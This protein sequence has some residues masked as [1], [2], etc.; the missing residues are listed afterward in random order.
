[1]VT[2]AD[3]V[4][5]TL[6]W[7]RP[8]V[9][10]AAVDGL[11]TLGGYVGTLVALL[12]YPRTAAR[13]GE[14]A[15]LAIDTM[16]SV[17]G[18][19]LL[20]WVLVTQATASLVAEPGTVWWVRVFGLSQLALIAGLNVVI[21]RG[22]AVPSTRAFWWFISGQAL[23]VPVVLLSQLFEARL[24]AAW[25]IDLVYY[26]GV[27]PTFV[28]AYLFRTDPMTAAPSGAGPTWLRD[29]NPL[30]LAM[31]L[32]VGG[33]LLTMLVVRGPAGPALPLAATLVAMSLLLALRLLLSAH[34]TAMQAREEAAREERRQ[35]DRL[36][37]VG[38]L[39]G[40][41]AHEFNNLMARVIGNTELGEASLPID[42]E[43]R[44]HFVRARTA[45]LRAAELTSQLLAFSG[46]RHTRPML[47]DAEAVVHEAV[48]QATRDAGAGIGVDFTAGPGPAAIFADPGQLRGAIAQLVDNALEAMPQGG[49]LSVS[50]VRQTL[51]APLGTSL[52]SVGAGTYVVTTVADTGVGMDAEAVRV[53]CEPFYS[54]KPAHLGAGL[55]LA[56]VHG[57]VASHDG[58]LVIDSTPGMGTTVRVY[59]PAA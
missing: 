43:A 2:A 52:L 33:A 16:V 4:A 41:I 37:A 57:F 6:P 13:P 47:L 59:L 12:I 42:A 27:L 3:Y 17:G 7:V 51:S 19:G 15:A 23:Y 40:G 39:A 26:L 10:H 46:Q 11:V 29:L 22:Q 56:V 28:A 45:A 53:A 8:F 54:T 38:R 49:R 31:P 48:Q 24:I 34:R 58:G 21:V 18:L 30:P 9:Q 50:V 20:S 35:A 5:L 55:G 36:Q 25:P 1:M 32:L 44:E 14:R